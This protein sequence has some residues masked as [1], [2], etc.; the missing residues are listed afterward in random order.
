MKKIENELFETSCDILRFYNKIELLNKKIKSNWHMKIPSAYYYFIKIKI[1]FFTLIGKNTNLQRSRK[2]I[3]EKIIRPKIRPSLK[4]IKPN[5]KVNYEKFVMQNV[6]KTL[7]QGLELLEDM[8][9]V[10]SLLKSK[11]KDLTKIFENLDE[12]IKTLEKSYNYRKKESSASNPG[13]AYEIC[14][15][16]APENLITIEIPFQNDFIDNVDFLF[17]ES[18]LCE[19]KEEDKYNMHNQDAKCPSNIHIYIFAEKKNVYFFYFSLI[20]KIIIN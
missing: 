5:K 11:I 8:N 4:F 6:N 13:N 1:N 7:N 17:A 3:L 16:S 10:D 12:N 9:Y 20:K 2:E 19:N 15:P 14:P 18:Y